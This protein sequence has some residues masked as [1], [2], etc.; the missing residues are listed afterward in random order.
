MKRI[1]AILMLISILSSTVPTFSITA[2]A[3]SVTYY[4]TSKD[5]VP[6]RY[7]IGEDNDIVSKVS[8]KGTVF[9][10]TETKKNK[11]TLITWTNWHKIIISPEL[12]N[13]GV[14]NVFWLWNGN[15][16]KHKHDM[17]NSVCQSL[18]CDYYEPIISEDDIRREFRVKTSTSAVRQY[19]Y[20]GGTELDRLSKGTPVTTFGAV[21]NS[22]NHIWYKLKEGYIYSENVEELT[23]ERNDTIS[24]NVT[25]NSN[26]GNSG[27]SGSGSTGSGSTGSGSTNSGNTGG[28]TNTGYYSPL[29]PKPCTHANWSVGKCVNCGKAWELREIAVNETFIAN[30]NVNALDIPYKQGKP[31]K[32]YT[33]GDVIPVVAK[34]ENSA[35]NIW[36]KTSDGYWVYNVKNVTLKRAVLNM[37]GYTFYSINETYTPKVICEPSNAVVS[38]SWRISDPNIA[39]INE[40]TGKITAKHSG[41]AEAVCKVESREG[42][43]V[44]LVFQVNVS[45]VADLVPWDYDNQKYNVDLALECAEYSALAYQQ[46]GYKL[47]TDQKVIITKRGSVESARGITLALGDLL[48]ERQFDYKISNNY[49]APSKDTSPL[50]IA[51]KKVRYNNSV[52]PKDLVFV[53]IQGSN[54]KE[55]WQG[56]MMVSGDNSACFDEH[57]SFYKA[58]V[59][60]E[61]Q[62]EDYLDENKIKNP[63]VVITG[64]SRGAAAG[65]LLA[66]SITNNSKYDKVYAYL[67][68]TPNTTQSPDTGLKNIINVCNELDFVT[69]MP[70][71]TN[72]GFKK[73]GRIYTFN[74]AE[75]LRTNGVFADM[76]ALEYGDPD[77]NWNAGTPTDI[78]DYVV[79]TWGTLD[80]YYHHDP[81]KY[82][83]CAEEAF[84]YFSE[85]LALAAS[86]SGGI[87][88]ML[89]HL[90]HVCPFNRLTCFFGVNGTVG[91]LAAFGDCHSMITYHAAMSTKK[92]PSTSK[93][94]LFSEPLYGNGIVEL[95]EEEFDAL[96][97]FFQQRDNELMLET[98]GWDIEDSSTWVGIKW[99][100]DGNV[101]DIDLSYLNLG[102]WFN[103]NNFPKLQ[104]LNLDGNAISMLVVSECTELVTLS[105]IANS[106][107]SLYVEECNNLQT[108]NCAFNNISSLDVSDMAQL[109]E[110]NCYGNQINDLDMSGAT[111]LQTVRCGNNEL[112][113]IDISTNTNLNTFLCSEN[114]IVESQ[115]ADLMN[116]MNAINLNGG[117]AVLGT[118]KYN[119]GYDFN[120][121]ELSSLSA[122]ANTSLNL[123][124]LGWDLD[125]PYSWEGVEWKIIGDEYHVTN[126]NFDNLDLEGDFNLPEAEYVESVSC[127]NSSLS[128]LNLSG[129]VNLS[130]VNCYNSGITSLEI[131]DCSSLSDLNCDE[132]FLEVADVESSLNQAGLSTGIA[133]YATQNITDGTEMF[134]QDEVNELIAFLCT[135]ANAEVLGWDWDWPGTWD[136]IIWR[137]VDDEY[138]ISRVD[139][140]DKPVC[141]E[142][143]LS[144]FSFLSYFNFSGT[145][146]ESVILPDCITKIPEYAFYNSAIKYI[147][148]QEGVTNIEKYA[149][150]YCENLNTVVLP[151]TVAKVLNCAFYECENLKNLVFLGDEPLIAGS[152]IAYGTSPEFKMI[153]FA[154]TNWNGTTQL[155]DTY[156][157][158]EV[159]E[160]Y[161][162]LLDETIELKEDAFYHET[163]NYGGDDVCVTIVARTPGDSATC[164][165]A[166]YDETGKLDSIRP[167][168][169]DMNSYMIVATVNDINIQYVGEEFCTLKAFL[170]SNLNSLKPLTTA[171]EKVLIK[172]VIE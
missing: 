159:A 112:Y 19:P 130:S 69:Y 164:L 38:T 42:T 85:G 26:T 133:T 113:S 148:M 22:K 59:D 138:R 151:K 23:G 81:N 166:V 153:C 157:H 100:T 4:E 102:G 57:Y 170:W 89:S 36:Y 122:F 62:L 135:G 82:S 172:P 114:R 3:A 21:K 67:F 83:Y 121:A 8:K 117:S 70:F 94:H 45:E 32:S 46:N 145:Q 154:G 99:N 43:V 44:N 52:V 106:I 109:S 169:V 111:T 28:S 78:R 87:T 63:L 56:N 29:P 105:C 91:K 143:D 136:G 144:G 79:G 146:V 86:K 6:L 65:N 14:N 35:H 5:S 60:A 97:S 165:L 37:S 108:L 10:V 61:E 124:K 110:L 137:K 27:S 17:K 161:I 88:N 12:T 34:A 41:K 2:S 93:A 162:V 72:W 139:L 76:M 58:A 40:S 49:Y 158:I 150:A 51:S 123:E 31:K 20:L 55:A 142:L 50:V 147:H 126:I 39:T 73:H 118:Q 155:M 95:N 54:T 68:A 132:N 141:G 131:A 119:E 101:V 90:L 64:H 9:K 24:N 96:N 104:N 77:Y 75:L 160:N 127:E 163:N 53:I 120:A 47:G 33:K 66:E 115:N 140:S 125:D 16:T 7:G 84:H 167:V 156:I 30:D 134:N 11:T 74:S 152:E 129:C 168:L 92:I 15:V 48:K 71:S 116:Q 98:V 107:G 149:F 18:G 1:L 171:T 128:T 80:E 103:A 25:N 13:N